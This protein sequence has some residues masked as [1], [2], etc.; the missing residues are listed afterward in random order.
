MALGLFTRKDEARAAQWQ[1]GYFPQLRSGSLA[2]YVLPLTLLLSAFEEEIVFRAFLW[3]RLKRLTG[4][5][6][7][8]LALSS[9]LFAAAH[10][11]SPAES[12]SLFLCGMLWGWA[13]IK[14]LEV[15]VAIFGDFSG[16]M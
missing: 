5:P 7:L 2:A 12:A 1:A 9:A 13:F 14:N 3:S 11:A 10:V 8:A 15:I 4:D 6:F 16:S